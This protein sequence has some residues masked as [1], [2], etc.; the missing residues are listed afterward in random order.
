MID[1]L[2]FHPMRDGMLKTLNWSAKF[3]LSMRKNASRMLSYDWC[4][5]WRH[6]NRLS[7]CLII[8]GMANCVYTSTGPGFPGTAKGVGSRSAYT[9]GEKTMPDH[10]CTWLW[11]HTSCLRAFTICFLSAR[12][13]EKS[14]HGE[15]EG[16]FLRNSAASLKVMRLSIFLDLDVDNV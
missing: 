10:L 9:I 11:G 14:G 5:F 7:A 12:S 8:V 3:A 15:R 2:A 16:R 1:M 13:F 4:S 6:K